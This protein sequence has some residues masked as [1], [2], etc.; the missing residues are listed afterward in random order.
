MKLEFENRRTH[1]RRVTSAPTM[2]AVARLN[3]RGH[4]MGR[5]INDNAERMTYVDARI[6][7][8][9]A[10]EQGTLARGIY[11]ATLTHID[12]IRNAEVDEG[13]KELYYAEITTRTLNH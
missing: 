3:L 1:N 12:S 10:L 7:L 6:L 8:D 5:R 2:L 9:N 13:Y 4:N 11:T